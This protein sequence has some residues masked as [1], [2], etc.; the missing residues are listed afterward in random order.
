MAAHFMAVVLCIRDFI[1][2]FR[3]LVLATA[4]QEPQR[5]LMKRWIFKKRVSQP[6][7]AV[8]LV[9]IGFVQSMA[10]SA[11]LSQPEGALSAPAVNR[12]SI[13]MENIARFRELQE[14]MKR[15]N[16]LE[17][18]GFFSFPYRMRHPVPCIRTAE[19]FVLR[20][21]EVLDET[22]RQQ[23]VDADP[24]AD[25]ASMGW[26][27]IM[28]G[29]G[30]VWFR[31]HELR[32]YAMNH[33]TEA[34][35][36]HRDH[37]INLQKREL[38]P[39]LRTFVQ[40]ELEQLTHSFRIRVDRLEGDT[41]RYAAWPRS[42][43]VSEEPSLVIEAGKIEFPGS[44]GNHQYVFTN[45]SYRYVIRVNDIGHRTSPPGEL[46]VFLRDEQILYQPFPLESVSNSYRVWVEYM[47]DGS[48]RL[49]LWGLDRSTTQ[50]PDKII[51][52][53]VVRYTQEPDGN[54]YVFE[55]DGRRYEVWNP[56]QY[57]DR[58]PP[59]RLVIL[60]EGHQIFEENLNSRP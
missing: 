53:G 34:F 30:L 20:I 32:I 47:Q 27:G 49:Q 26:R 40:P 55:Q 37:I 38:H 54:L 21:D 58:R 15:N 51:P 46:E 44:G 48:V 2:G 3:R 7:L 1:N 31:E 50:S 45:G 23:I 4:R 33:R 5:M 17:L 19:E 41:F 59:R 39:S 43:P 12:R 36:N 57:E 24:D 14:A 8:A 28:L 13:T 35:Q 60:E 22:L 18:A 10:H 56:F 16:P 25:V 29:S 6:A 11:S 9:G 42:R 52:D